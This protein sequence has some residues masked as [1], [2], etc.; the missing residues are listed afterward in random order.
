MLEYFGIIVDDKVFYTS[1]IE[2]SQKRIIMVNEDYEITSLT[3]HIEKQRFFYGNFFHNSYIANYH[4]EDD[5]LE[6]LQVDENIK[7][8]VITLYTKNIFSLL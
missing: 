4:N 5:Q 3:N 2:T 8:K 7:H 1:Y 6:F